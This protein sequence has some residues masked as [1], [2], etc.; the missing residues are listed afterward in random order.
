MSWL[1]ASA[2]IALFGANLFAWN[3]VGYREGR[4]S[5]FR[6]IQRLHL[7]DEEALKQASADQAPAERQTQS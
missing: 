5:V 2:L 3:R 4:I 7:E 1:E 6:E